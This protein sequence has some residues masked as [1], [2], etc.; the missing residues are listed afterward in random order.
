MEKSK[1]LLIDDYRTISGVDKIA[2]TY[3]AGLEAILNEGPWSCIVF[4]H[5]LACE[6]SGY[7]LMCVLEEKPELIPDNI[8]IITDNAAARPK[9]EQLKNRLLKIKNGSINED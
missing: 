3:D 9:M 2:R 1:W 8:I 6:K 7:D 4:D 5:D